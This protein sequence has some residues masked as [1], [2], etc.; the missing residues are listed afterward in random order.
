MSESTRTLLL[1]DDESNILHALER[2][3]RRDGYRILACDDPRQALD[4]LARESVDV[5]LCD[6]RMPG[7]SGVE[8][9]RRAKETHPESV[10]I[11]LSGYTDLQFIT[12]A[13][14][15]GAIFKFLTKPWDDAQLRAQIQEAFHYKEVH[16]ENRRLTQALQDANRALRVHAEARERQAQQIA[17]A[18][19][20]LQ[21]V[22]QI[23]PSPLL[24]VDAQ[25]VIALSNAAADASLGGGAALLGQDAAAVLPQAILSWLNDAQARPERI[26]LHD[27]PYRVYCRP[28]GRPAQAR[29][30]LLSLLPCDLPT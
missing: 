9:L 12:D 15:E 19:D 16:D 7:M 11:V 1:V 23:I 13:V 27:R 20:M 24:G 14:N 30:V 18:L 21:E 25:G 3:L 10:R 8:F 29:G 6:Q 5:I 22:L 4:V 2:T 26:L 17:A 28:L